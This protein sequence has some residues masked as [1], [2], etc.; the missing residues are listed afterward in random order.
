MIY[1]YSAGQFVQPQAAG[2]TRPP[3]WSPMQ[4]IPA[5]SP[6]VLAKHGPSQPAVSYM[7]PME[8]QGG[9][10]VQSSSQSAIHPV[11]MVNLVAGPC[12]P[13]IQI[14][15]PRGISGQSHAN[16][17]VLLR[18]VPT[19]VR[20]EELAPWSAECSCILGAEGEEARF[21]GKAR[22]IDRHTIAEA[23]EGL[24]KHQIWCP[25]DC[26]IVLSTSQRTY[27]LLYRRGKCDS[28]FAQIG[29]R[30]D[31]RAGG[32]SHHGE[33]GLHGAIS[34]PARASSPPPM[35]RPSMPEASCTPVH[36]VVRQ[37][38]LPTRSSGA[39][40]SHH[41]W[42]KPPLPVG[43]AQ[44][45]MPTPSSV[46]GDAAVG[47]GACARYASPA[48]RVSQATQELTRPTAAWAA[49]RDPRGS[50]SAGSQELPQPVTSAVTQ[51]DDP[52]HRPT[53]T[54]VQCSGLPQQG[55]SASEG[56]VPIAMPPSHRQST[57]RETLE[58][59]LTEPEKVKYSDLK[60]VENLGSGEFGQV[61]RGTFQ[62]EEV[63]IKE[64]YWDDTMT[65]L[66]MQDLAREI[67]SF[68]HLRHKRLVRFIGACLE[69]PHP[70]L[71]TEYAPG[72]SLHHLLHVRKLQLPLLHGT[73]MCLQ[74]ADG[75]MYLHSQNPT[76]VHRDLKSLNVVLDLSLNIKI[77]DF[78]LTE[79][80]ERTHITKKN[81]GGSPRYMAPE[82]F[83][84]KTKITEK[85]DVWAMGCIFIEIFGG[86]LPYETIST[87]ADLTREMLMH[88]RGPSVP[89]SI[90]QEIRGII[91]SCLNFDYRLRPSSKQ[92]FEQ[93]KAAKKLLRASG[94][95]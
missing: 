87:L 73:N 20:S 88:R 80:M 38:S 74:V 49:V 75:V 91:C 39:E 71:V 19:P 56:D 7:P 3:G 51:Q 6:S 68:R 65:E 78:G 93:L 35:G 67:E 70:C 10:M 21:A 82:L 23:V 30:K 46:L 61:Y 18:A 33:G 27:H 13:P 45:Y 90:P 16:D 60:F 72:G 12:S 34:V 9:G 53:A 58:R 83:D 69:L 50:S 42:G 36:K 77:C 52:S 32:S 8:K 79:P 95:L 11:N 2:G 54:P 84:C 66:V 25:E 47:S 17:P 57:P 62:G 55:V 28:A 26:C 15:A 76:I 24:N 44:S 43:A 4:V 48:P 40:L 5:R 37:T 63:A 64:L 81:N 29:I 22:I 94:R 14:R 31:M 85:I 86:P 89:P 92:T 41:L 59:D 1:Q